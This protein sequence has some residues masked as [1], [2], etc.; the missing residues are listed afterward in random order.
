MDKTSY[1]NIYFI[2]SGAIATS[3]ATVF[4]SRVRFSCPEAKPWPS[5]HVKQTPD[6]NSAAEEVAM[7]PEKKL[8]Y[9]LCTAVPAQ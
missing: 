8:R 2:F 6:P 3:S 7:A 5:K 9:L 4:G 1:H